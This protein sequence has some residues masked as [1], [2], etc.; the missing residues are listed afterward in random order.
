MKKHFFSFTALA[1]ALLFSAFTKPQTVQKQSPD[2]PELVWY[3]VNGSGQINLSTPINANEP[4][5]A[6]ELLQTYSSLC[7]TGTE[8]DCVRGFDPQYPPVYTTDIGIEQIKK[9]Q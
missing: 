9:N 3:S 6:A 2:N 1:L 4:M 5:T 7:A 8:V